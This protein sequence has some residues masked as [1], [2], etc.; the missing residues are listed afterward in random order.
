MSTWKCLTSGGEYTGFGRRLPAWQGI[1]HGA[2]EHSPQG[3][4]T[5]LGL[6]ATQVDKPTLAEAG[7]DKNL[8]R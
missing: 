2:C 1:G 4:R 7:I 3:K 6:S 8:G 5:D